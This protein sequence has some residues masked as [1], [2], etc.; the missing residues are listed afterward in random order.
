[1]P[2]L[3][4]WY[5]GS[6]FVEHADLCFTNINFKSETLA[7]NL[8]NVNYALEVI[9]IASHNTEIVNIVFTMNTFSSNFNPDSR[10]GQ[11]KHSSISRY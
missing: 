1:M 2:N 5:I 7:K 3:N 11:L 8:N 10:A 6:S 9:D 4:I